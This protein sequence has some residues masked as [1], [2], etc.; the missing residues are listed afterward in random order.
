VSHKIENGLNFPQQQQQTGPICGIFPHCGRCEGYPS[1]DDR[2]RT[3]LSRTW[4]ALRLPLSLW[5][6]W[7]VVVDLFITRLLLFAFNLL[8]ALP[9]CREHGQESEENN[10]FSYRVVLPLCEA[11]P[12]GPSFRHLPIG[13]QLA[14]LAAIFASMT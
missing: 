14:A 9:A 12:R 3:V 4:A 8:H 1:T 2:R 13:T 6:Q 7:A 11:G 5:F 10:V